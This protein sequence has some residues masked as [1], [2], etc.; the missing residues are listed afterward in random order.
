MTPLGSYGRPRRFC[1]FD[2]V[3]LDTGHEVAIDALQVLRGVR[4]AK[5][6][7][8][9]CPKVSIRQDQDDFAR[10]VWRVVVNNVGLANDVDGAGSR[11][12]ITPNIPSRAPRYPAT[13]LMC[14][15]SS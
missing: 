15:S 8:H 12:A 4:A 10:H 14:S 13:W 1:R 3:L 9:H 11:V 6:L 7:L 5:F 2:E